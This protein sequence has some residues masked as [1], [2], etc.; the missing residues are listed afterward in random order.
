MPKRILTGTVTS[1]QN[2]QTV[3]V[4]VERRFTHPVLKK[5]IR[6]SKKYRAHDEKNAFNVGDKVRIQECAP[7]SKTKRWEVLS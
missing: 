5:T 2:A 6:K 4:S 3:T 1:N 7:K